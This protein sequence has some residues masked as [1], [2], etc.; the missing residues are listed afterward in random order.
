MNRFTK[1]TLDVHAIVAGT[2]AGALAQK[3]SIRLDPVTKD[4]YSLTYLNEGNCHIKVEVIDEDGIILLSEQIDQNK[5]FT[6]P[7]SF[8]NLSLGEYSFKVTDAEGVYLTRKKRTNEINKVAS[9]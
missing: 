2:N 4:L 3:K 9:F 1:T 6:K 5:S 8:Q 7:Y